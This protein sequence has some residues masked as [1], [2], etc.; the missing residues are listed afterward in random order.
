L[1]GFG[2]GIV[3]ASTIRYMTFGSLRAIAIPIRPSVD[4]GKPPPFTWVQVSPPSVLFQ[5]ADP[6][7]PLLRK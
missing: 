4:S 2:F 1:A 3:S 6:G 7:P 5:S